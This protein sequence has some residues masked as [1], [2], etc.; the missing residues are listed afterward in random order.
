MRRVLFILLGL[1][2]GCLQLSL[3]GLSIHAVVPNI[4]LV[5]LVA[6]A[7]S[8]SLSEL[9]CLALPL[10]LVLEIGSLAPFGTQLLSVLIFVLATKLVLRA[11]SDQQRLGYLFILLIA[12]TAIMNIILLANMG[13][14]IIV[15][16][17]R[18]L[19]LRIALEA[20][21]NSLLFAVWLALTQRRQ[22]EPS[23]YRLPK[24]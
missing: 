17:I 9:L 15:G 20:L 14:A 21:Y 4:A 8:T 7:P 23:T 24:L 22:T 10:G 13:A 12:A 3:H 6:A 1:A 16:S 11:A 18:Y 19:A 5:A 2:V